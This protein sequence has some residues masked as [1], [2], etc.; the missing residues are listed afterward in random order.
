M[1]DDIANNSINPTPGI[2][3]NRPNGTNVYQ[4]VPK[5]YTGDNVTPHNFLRVLQ[6]IDPG[7]GTRKVIN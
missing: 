6:G 5:D 3:V 2:I 1:Y 7:V 4:G